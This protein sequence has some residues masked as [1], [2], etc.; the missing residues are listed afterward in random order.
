HIYAIRGLYDEAISWG[1]RCIEID[2]LNKSPY[3]TLALSY[4]GK[5]RLNEAAEKI[6]K[7]IYIDP[8]FTLGYFTLGN[9]YI[10]LHLKSQADTFSK[11]Q[12]AH[13]DSCRPEEISFKTKNT[14]VR[15]LLD[16]LQLQPRSFKE[17]K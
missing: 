11:K 1:T 13:S 15:K 9:I 14:S 4:I 10:L 5:G 6:K 12:K 7:A 16:E 8:E 17:E 3:Y 2:P